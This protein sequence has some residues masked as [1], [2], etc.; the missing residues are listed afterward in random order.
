MIVLLRDVREWEVKVQIQEVGQWGI[1]LGLSWPSTLSASPFLFFF[2][3][4]MWLALSDP[5]PAPHDRLTPVKIEAK[6]NLQVLSCSVWYFGH[7]YIKITN[8]AIHAISLL[9]LQFFSEYI[10]SC[11]MCWFPVR[12]GGFG[13]MRYCPFSM[14][15][16]SLLHGVYIPAIFRQN[17]EGIALRVPCWVQV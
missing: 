2:A 13:L 4:M 10:L 1:S 15:C 6:Y 14:F 11:P 17:K 8:T 3:N 12:W 9:Q 7:N 5:E 16:R